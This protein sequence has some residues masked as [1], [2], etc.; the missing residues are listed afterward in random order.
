MHCDG[1][2]RNEGKRI[3]GVGTHLKGGSQL[4]PAVGAHIKD[5]PNFFLW[6][7]EK[8]V[9]SDEQMIDKKEGMFK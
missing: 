3:P 4:F 2:R 8:N 5:E 9:Y 1:D 6:N 7:N